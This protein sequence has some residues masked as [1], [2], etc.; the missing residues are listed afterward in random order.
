V[1]DLKKLCPIVPT[2]ILSPNRNTNKISKLRCSFHFV[3]YVITPWLE[4]ASELYR[5]SDCRFSAKL[6]P[7]FADRGSHMI[8]VTDPY[9]HILG[10]L[11]RSRYF[12]F[13]IA[14][15]LYSRGQVDPVSDPL[16]LRK[17]SSRPVRNINSYMR[18]YR[19]TTVKKFISSFRHIQKCWAPL[20]TSN[21]R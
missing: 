6:V 2:L 7:T 3:Q 18:D 12:F 10:S 13:Q 1:S 20:N 19:N 15:Q 16:L 5:P 14:P 17:S 11:D 8:S 9:G 4:S 21:F